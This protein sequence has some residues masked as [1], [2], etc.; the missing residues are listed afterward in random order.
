MTV[1]G[2]RASANCF[3]EALQLLASGR[4]EYPKVATEFRLWD[5][6]AVF[7]RLHADPGAV[8]KGVLVL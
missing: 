2:S 1:V 5:A 3:P 4:I 7:E 8:H 6:P